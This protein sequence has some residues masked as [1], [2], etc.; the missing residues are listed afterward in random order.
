MGRSEDFFGLPVEGSL[1]RGPEPDPW[2]VLS[3]PASP[4]PGIARSGPR[5]IAVLVAVSLAAGAISG[6]VA[7]RLGR[8]PTR[9]PGLPQ[10][11]PIQVAEAGSLSDLVDQVAPAVVYMS[12]RVATLPEVLGPVP[13]PGIVTGIVVDDRGYIVTTRSA[14]EKAPSLGVFLADGRQFRGQ[15]IRASPDNDVAIVKIDDAV[16]LPVVRLARSIDLNVGDPVVAVGN[17]LSFGGGPTVSQ[18]VVMALHRKIPADNLDG[19]IQTDALLGATMAG[20]PLLNLAGQVVGLGVTAPS[21]GGGSY[22]IGIDSIRPFIDQVVQRKVPMSSGVK[23]ATLTPQLAF[24][25]GIQYTRGVIV[26]DVSKGGPGDLATLRPG[27]VITD[28]DGEPAESEER[29]MRLTVAGPADGEVVL[30]V[31]RGQETV[32]LTLQLAP[33]PAP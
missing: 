7:A 28:I 30:T 33:I 3:G 8:E 19:L 14:V 23:V 15:V 11:S 6:F 27:D 32:N 16:S 20:G 10:A 25:V 24:G 12:T 4:Q 21:G 22:A 26:T 1:A 29:F 17:A 2:A 9:P 31:V 5:I 18:G 13:P